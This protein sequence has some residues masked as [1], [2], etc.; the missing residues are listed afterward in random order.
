MLLLKLWRWL[1]MKNELVHGKANKPEPSAQLI[2]AIIEDRTLPLYIGPNVLLHQLRFD[3]AKICSLVSGW[4][5]PETC[6][7]I[8]A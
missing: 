2:K 3:S 6:D 1:F 8:D 5:S 4:Y 7:P